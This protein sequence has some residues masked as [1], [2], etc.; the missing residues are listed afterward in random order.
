MELQVDKKPLVLNLI[1]TGKSEILVV[2]ILSSG[3]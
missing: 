2:D 1:T 3:K